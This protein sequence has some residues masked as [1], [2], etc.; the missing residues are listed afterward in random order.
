M[1]HITKDELVSIV[2][3]NQWFVQGFNGFALYCHCVATNTAWMIKPFVGAT[4]KHFFLLQRE[5]SVDWYYDEA[6]MEQVGQGYYKHIKTLARL[7]QLERIYTR[8]YISSRKKTDTVLPKDLS[9]IT[10]QQL[11]RVVAQLAEELKMSVNIAHMQEGISFVSEPKLVEILEKRGQYTP[12]NLQ[13]LSAPVEKSFLA[14][15]QELLARIK[16]AQASSRNRLAQHFLKE[17]GWI[18]NSYVTG[19]TLSINDVLKKAKEQKHIASKEHEGKVKKAK[20]ALVTKLALTK[21]ELFVVTTVERCAKWQDTRK[22][23]I[24]QSIGRFEPVIAELSK[25]VGL[26]VN[27]LKYT[28]PEELTYKNL[29]S[30]A[31]LKKLSQRYPLCAQYAT[32]RGVQSFVGRD[33]LF[34]QK[35]VVKNKGGELTE[36]QGMVAS[37][38]IAR[39]RV[40]VCK[41]I[42]DIP[43]VKKG[44]ILIA[45]MTRPEFLPAMQKAIAFVTDEG[46]VTSHAAIVSCEM[47]KP[48]IIGTKIATKVFQD[49]D[50]VEVD[51][52]KGIVKKI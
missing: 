23:H 2:Q 44:E 26:S 35:N 41:S 10:L 42:H 38:G 3:K 14:E 5:S 15:A 18:D 21:E 47:R 8:T 7:Q 43:K 39:G 27:Q 12:E 19:K 37:A 45:S 46:G 9:T 40:R 1:K 49:G 31:F 17:Y 51:A 32:P 25:R 16:N 22:K 50:F 34:I 4:Y 24:M 36:L 48:C 11:V 33:A 20:R 30:P 6:A 13:L 52:I 28:A 29:T